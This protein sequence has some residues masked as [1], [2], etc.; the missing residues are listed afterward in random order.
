MAG[1]FLM[2]SEKSIAKEFCKDDLSTPPS[3]NETSNGAEASS[4]S[5]TGDS[6]TMSEFSN[7]GLINKSARI[8]EVVSDSVEKTVVIASALGSALHANDIVCLDGDLGAGKTAFTRGIAIALGIKDII[9]SPTFT[10][11]IEHQAGRIPL[12]HF[13]AYRLGDEDEFMNL[14]FDEY[15]S[16]G[17]VCVVEWAERIKGVFPE[18]AIQIFLIRKDFAESDIRRI[19]FCFPK[20]DKRYDVFKQRIEALI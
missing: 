18:T 16:C 10:I 17:G 2:Q 3:F 4:I 19:S 20:E 9:P 1:W 11:L 7:F 15:F 8:I 12:Y 6:S 5:S 13:D 14:G